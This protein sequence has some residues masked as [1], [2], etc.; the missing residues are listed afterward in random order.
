MHQI[1]CL[2][3]VKPYLCI[4]YYG[5]V[6][7]NCR[8]SQTAG[9]QTFPF[10]FKKQKQEQTLIF[11]FPTHCLLQNLSQEQMWFRTSIISNYGIGFNIK[12]CLLESSSLPVKRYSLKNIIFELNQSI[13][14]NQ[15]DNFIVDLS[16]SIT[17][18]RA[19]PL[20]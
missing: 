8:V 7:L 13:K 3:A 2:D 10:N 6:N 18:K 14:F 5:N 19:E 20:V 16:K 17:H 15:L 1:C 9:C 11:F 12:T 4:T